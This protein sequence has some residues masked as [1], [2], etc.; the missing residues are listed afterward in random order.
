MARD[1]K[2]FS[3]KKFKKRILKVHA[4][5]VESNENQ[6]NSEYILNFFVQDILDFSQV[7]AGIFRKNCQNFR[8]KEAID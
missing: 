4:N 8:L 2:L 6:G 3:L 1:K 5:L 7:N